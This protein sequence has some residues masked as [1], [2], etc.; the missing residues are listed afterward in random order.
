MINDKLHKSNSIF[1][2]KNGLNI[3]GNKAFVDLKNH[4]IDFLNV[5]LDLGVVELK[6]ISGLNKIINLTS[7]IY[8]ERIN[9]MIYP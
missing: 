6:N 8:N 4:K 5:T 9:G 7:G 2:F 1:N 3:F